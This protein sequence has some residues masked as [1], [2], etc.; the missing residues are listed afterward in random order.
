MHE[1]GSPSHHEAPV[2]NR[3]KYVH[4][5]ENLLALT[6]ELIPGQP[7]VA[8]PSGREGFVG[9]ESHTR[10]FASTDDFSLQPIATLG[11][12]CPSWM[13]VNPHRLACRPNSPRWT[14]WRSSNRWSAA[15]GDRDRVGDRQRL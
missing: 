14:I 6:L 1:K 8:S 5:T 11:R 4:A 9:S 10:T 15:V 3:R 13:V 12:S 2:P 7:G